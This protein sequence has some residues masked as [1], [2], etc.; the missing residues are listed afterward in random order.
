MG[1]C[2]GIDLGTTNS[3]AAFRRRG[4]VEYVLD[5]GGSPVVPSAVL[6]DPGGAVVGAPALARGLLRSESLVVDSKRLIGDPKAFWSIGGRR[7]DATDVAAE[8]LAYLRRR[9]EIQLGASVDRAVVTVPAYFTSA[10]K[11]ATK[12]AGERAGFRVERLIPEPTAAAVS[13]GIDRHC[14]QT[15]LVYDLGGGTFDVSIVR[16]RAP[17]FEVLAVHGDARLGG[18]DLDAAIARWL[19]SNVPALGRRESESL[20]RAFDDPTAEGVDDPLA[21]AARR[22][23]SAAR[24]AKAEL[25]EAEETDVILAD[26]LG[27]DLDLTLT[28]AQ[29]ETIV[30]PIVERT[31]ASIEAALAGA[32]L[33]AD[34]VDR[35][36]LA[37]GSTKLPL[38]RRL[39]AERYREPWQAERLD[40]VVASGAATVAASLDAP[41]P[42]GAPS[43]VDVT[44]HALG[45]RVA[46]GAFH[47]L[48]PGNTPLPATATYDGFTTVRTNQSAVDVHVFQGESPRAQENAFVGG[49]V[50]GGIPPAKPGEPRIA[51]S[52]RMD[53][54]DLLSV[55][56]SCGTRQATQTLD[57]T[58]RSVFEETR[59]LPS[60]DVVFLIDTSGSMSGELE[61]IK[62][63]CA[64][65]ASAV[66]AGGVDARLGLVDFDLP[67]DTSS[68]NVETFGPMPP[69]SFP[70]AIAGLRIGRLGG[71]GCYVGD[72]ESVDVF[73]AVIRSFDARDRLKIAVLVSDE[74]GNDASAIGRIVALLRQSNVT[75]H[76]VGVNGSCHERIAQQTGGRFWSIDDTRS[77]DFG[78]LLASIASEVTD[79]A[80]RQSA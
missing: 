23:L 42:T 21:A 33:S 62:A 29:L 50:L 12:A 76:A 73:E 64:D 56:A 44:P 68:Y 49:F 60:V 48:I 58:L 3:V 59:P 1:V 4:E 37:G 77:L 39:L 74:V 54:S 2:V 71:C 52:F 46:G 41:S 18:R 35:F 16:V 14:D 47:V 51:V 67:S 61:G 80:L 11:Q 36:V 72:A 53:G 69:A 20:S 32:R 65:F 17:E 75:M 63:R 79:L 78:E 25:T 24:A 15:V 34:E 22:L 8:I 13:Y 43:I 10:Q 45:V 26:W 30:R 38:I 19:A 7:I 6:F 5:E 66:A 28:R 31:F 27:R 55:A 40:L 70:S 9:A 57:V